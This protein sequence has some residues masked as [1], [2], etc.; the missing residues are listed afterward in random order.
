MRVRVNPS[1]ATTTPTV[2]YIDTNGREVALSHLKYLLNPINDAMLD[3]KGI[4]DM[5]E[6][7][8]FEETVPLKWRDLLSSSASF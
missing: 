8:S 3:I 1:E 6:H 4:P 7:R 5:G 2:S